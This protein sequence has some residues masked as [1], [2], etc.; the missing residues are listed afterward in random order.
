MYHIINIDTSVVTRNRIFEFFLCG[1]LNSFQLAK[2]DKL[3]NYIYLYIIFAHII[4]VDINVAYK[5]ENLMK[6]KNR[7]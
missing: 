5:R 2:I 3:Y 7:N 1:P 6:L 4:R